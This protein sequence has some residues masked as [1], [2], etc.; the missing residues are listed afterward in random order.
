MK[1]SLL[2]TVLA[3]PLYW[4]I[5]VASAWLLLRG[6]NAPGGGFIAG[7]V[8][9][10]ASVLWAIAHGAAAAAARLPLRAPLPLAT[11]GVALALLAGAVALGRG[12]P[13]LTHA[14]GE[15]GG[16]PLSTV[17]LFDLGVYATVWGAIAGYAL[18]LIAA[19]EEDDAADEET[20]P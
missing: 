18:A 17:L 20:A 9:S 19:G 16:V 15:W 6:H 11:A 2:L 8:A 14:W 1:R 10:T 12:Q 4:L 7:L 13:F 5:L 3:A